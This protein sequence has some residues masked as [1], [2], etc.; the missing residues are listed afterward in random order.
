[1][2]APT[3]PTDLQALLRAARGRTAAWMFEVCAGPR[4]S[5]H[6]GA[7]SA[8]EGGDGRRRGGGERRG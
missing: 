2:T 8:R 5:A 4:P 1:M 3:A 7:A 6:L